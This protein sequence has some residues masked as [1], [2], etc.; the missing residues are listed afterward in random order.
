MNPV[1]LLA[2]GLAMLLSL[3]VPALRVS[4][5]RAAE[6]RHLGKRLDT[7]RAPLEEIEE[8]TSPRHQAHWLMARAPRFIRLWFARAG[9]TLQW[10]GAILFG[11]GIAATGGVAFLFGGVVVGVA[12]TIAAFGLVLAVFRI[13]AARRLA[14]FVDGLPLYLDGTRQLVMVGNSLQQAMVKA[15]EGCG[16]GVTRHLAPLLR[17][18]QFGAPPGDSV[19]WLAERLDII[20]LHMLAAAI[21]TNARFGG[22]ISNVLNNLTQILRDRARVERE[23]HSATAET[24]MSALILGALPVVVAVLISAT[25]PMYLDFFMNEPQGH[26]LIAIALGMEMAGVLVMR[27][28]MRIDF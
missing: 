14:S 1:M 27:R 9:V 16:P 23:L 12:G 6:R 15:G 10:R 18:V 11:L 20:E 26:K 24:R 5:I 3:G 25:N 7:V 21:Q 17:R 13:I 8:L 22:R 4:R 19:A 2:A 28:I